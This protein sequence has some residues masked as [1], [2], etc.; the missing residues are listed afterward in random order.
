MSPYNNHQ[1]HMHNS[2]L[3]RFEY[4]LILT[5]NFAHFF[6]SLMNL[7][8]EDRSFRPSSPLTLPPILSP[9]QVSSEKGNKHTCPSVSTSLAYDVSSVLSVSSPTEARQGSP[10]REKGSKDGPQ[11]PN[12]NQPHLSCWE[13]HLKTKLCMGSAMYV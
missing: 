7:L 6:S 5:A 4:Y 10:A 3:C 2:H 8:H 9:V 1:H 12:Q 11:S 13:T